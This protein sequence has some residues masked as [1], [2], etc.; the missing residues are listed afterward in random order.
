MTHGKPVSYYVL[1]HDHDLEGDSKKDKAR[2]TKV[3]GPLVS[4]LVPA[5]PAQKSP[6]SNPLDIFRKK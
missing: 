3:F 2:N 5:C 1:S 6:Y 4:I